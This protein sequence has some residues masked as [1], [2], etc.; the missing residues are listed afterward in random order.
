VSIF[1]RD[2]DTMSAIRSVQ[3]KRRSRSALALRQSPWN[4]EVDAA[5]RGTKH[6]PE[7]WKETEELTVV[8]QAAGL[9]PMRRFPQ[10][11]RGLRTGPYP[12]DLYSITQPQPTRGMKRYHDM[13]NS[14]LESTWLPTQEP[15]HGRRV[16]PVVDHTEIPWRA[17][18]AKPHKLETEDGKPRGLRAGP[19]LH[20]YDSVHLDHDPNFRPLE[21]RVA[22]EILSHEA[23]LTS[24]FGTAT[25]LRAHPPFPG[26]ARRL[27]SPYGTA[28]NYS[29]YEPF[30]KYTVHYDTRDL[31]TYA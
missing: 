14:S 20:L 21:R 30:R 22:G 3:K 5:P 26:E 8:K 12:N 17:P 15:P 13:L 1:F 31:L 23:R 29:F 4:G 27:Q 28:H 11:E 6:F 25:H 10:G 2:S 24:C 16:M 9:T 18:P 19:N 7:S